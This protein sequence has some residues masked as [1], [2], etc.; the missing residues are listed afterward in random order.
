MSEEKIIL[1]VVGNNDS[2]IIQADFKT[3]QEQLKTGREWVAEIL[4]RSGDYPWIVSSARWDSKF[5]TGGGLVEN[6]E[7]SFIVWGVMYRKNYIAYQVDR[8]GEGYIAITPLAYLP[9]SWKIATAVGLAIFYIVPLVLAPL[10][11]RIYQKKSLRNSKVF[12]PAFCQYLLTP[13]ADKT[14]Q[15]NDVALLGAGE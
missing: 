13:K 3:V 9:K 2:A 1:N 4:Q 6:G 7:D 11:W 8:T 10:F 12:L 5:V 14:S 15:G